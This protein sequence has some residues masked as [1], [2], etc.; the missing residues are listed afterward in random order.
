MFFTLSTYGQYEERTDKYVEFGNKE[1]LSRCT[2]DHTKKKKKTLIKPHMCRVFSWKYTKN[3]K[4][5]Q[6][7]WL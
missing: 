1:K 4:A 2:C 3:Y 5:Q 6:P 7:E